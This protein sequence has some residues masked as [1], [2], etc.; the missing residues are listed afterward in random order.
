MSELD[1]VPLTMD[2]LTMP[3]KTTNVSL[4]SLYGNEELTQTLSCLRVPRHF[5]ALHE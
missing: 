4:T 2:V 1:I 3:P 5:S